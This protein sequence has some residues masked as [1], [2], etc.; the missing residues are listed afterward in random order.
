MKRGNAAS[1][2]G[3]V[4]YGS[5]LEIFFIKIY[6]YHT[7]GKLNVIENKN[8]FQILSRPTS[9]IT[10]KVLC[11][12]GKCKKKNE[13]RGESSDG[14]RRSAGRM[15]RKTKPSRGTPDKRHYLTRMLNTSTSKWVKKTCKPFPEENSDRTPTIILLPGV[16]K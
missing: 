8:V 12:H 15:Y 13:W 14:S 11:T 2:P 1:L 4:P 7:Y 3:T 5:S 10:N 9:I 16:A 6:L